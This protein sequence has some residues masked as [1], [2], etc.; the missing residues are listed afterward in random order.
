MHLGLFA[1][2]Q[3]SFPESTELE[4]DHSLPWQLQ[5]N[6][7]SLLDLADLVYVDPP[8]TGYSRVAPE[9]DQNA[10]YSVDADA[11]QVANFITQWLHQH[12]R[13]QAPVFL[14]G[15]SYGTM[16]AAA[17]TKQLLSAK[18]ALN[19]SGVML[20]GQAVN[21]I[22][23]SQ[24]PN[25]ALSYVAS[26]PTLAL[27]AAYHGKSAYPNLSPD[28][29]FEKAWQYGLSDYLQALVL[30]NRISSTQLQQT[31]E[32]LERLTGISAEYY[33]QHR[34]KIT[35]PE[36]RT[37]LLPNKILGYYDARYV[38]DYDPEQPVDA[39][40]A[41]GSGFQQAHAAYLK[42]E[43]KYAS[44]EGYVL[45]A[46]GITSLADWQWGG[47]SPFSHFN[48][49]AYLD[50]AF[51]Q[52][53]GFHLFVGSGYYDL[54]TTSGGAKYLVQ[55]SEWPAEQVMLR[56]YIGGHMAYTVPQSA[57]ALTADTRDFIQRALAAA[58]KN[59]SQD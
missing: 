30:G 35:K 56:N 53:P 6:P 45:R 16:R 23:Y 27:I 19:L 7:Q 1:P 43:L 26:L 41:L 4:P 36:F 52:L 28:E 42:N 2:Y 14:F 32:E 31:A 39:S 8:E 18:P 55:Q 12:Q 20:F 58:P 15:E 34:L 24:R 38:A 11:Q 17:V 59:H 33:V 22:E 37:A 48:Y 25:N 5:K 40:S 44:P 54:T 51:Q 9:R 21:M 47:N 50:E 3:A 46:P 13:E 57:R 49:A 29:L 10:F